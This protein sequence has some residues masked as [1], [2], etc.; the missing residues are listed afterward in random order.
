M[1]QIRCTNISRNVLLYANDAIYSA[2]AA[3]TSVYLSVMLCLVVNHLTIHLK[4]SLAVV[5]VF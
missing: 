2:S 4:I 5:L 1:Y 3:N